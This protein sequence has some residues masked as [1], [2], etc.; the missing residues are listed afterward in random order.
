MEGSTEGS[1]EGSMG[2]SRRRLWINRGRSHCKH[3]FYCVWHTLGS[4]SDDRNIKTNLNRN[5]QK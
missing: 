3:C 2:D 4:Y 1:M 5:I